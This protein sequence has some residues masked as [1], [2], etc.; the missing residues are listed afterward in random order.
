MRWFWL[1]IPDFI[2]SLLAYPLAPL[3]VLF[4]NSQGK[5]P[6]WAFPWLTHDNPID[7]DKGHWER[8]PDDAHWYDKFQRRTAWLWRNRGYNF[9]YYVCG[10]TT[11]SEVEIKYGKAFW[12]DEN[13]RGYCFATCGK[14]WMLFAWLPYSRTRGLRIYLGWKLRNKIDKPEENSRAMLVTHINPFKGKM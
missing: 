9:S 8:W 13:P 14:T 12:K 10:V 1:A 7:G 5:S 11:S 3:I 4:T 2:I 6:L